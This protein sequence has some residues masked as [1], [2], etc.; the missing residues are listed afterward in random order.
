MPEENIE[1]SEIPIPSGPPN[2]EPAGSAP[3]AATPAAPPAVIPTEP[4]APS[5]PPDPALAGAQARVAEL[6]KAIA[7]LRA[8]DQAAYEDI[9]GKIAAKEAALQA[10]AAKY[11]ALVL[12]ANPEIPEE[13]LPAG[14]SIEELETSLEKA[15]AII[16]KVKARLQSQAQS[17]PVPAGAPPRSGIDLSALSAREK[18][19]LGIKPR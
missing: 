15:K 3:P 17:T 10:T 19:A 14:A 9:S 18:I 2:P 13:L 4:P 1:H 7:D 16:G 11:R 5:A 8:K 12:A 6:E